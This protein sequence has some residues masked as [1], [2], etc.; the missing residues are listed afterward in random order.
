[1][2]GSERVGENDRYIQIIINNFHIIIWI[3]FC[4]SHKRLLLREILIL[5]LYCLDLR[6]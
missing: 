3:T 6:I 1:M 4:I 5:L 2:L